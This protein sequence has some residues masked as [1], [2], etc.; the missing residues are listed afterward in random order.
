MF[1][2]LHKSLISKFLQHTLTNTHF[3]HTHTLTVTHSRLY[4]TVVFTRWS[5]AKTR[6]QTENNTGRV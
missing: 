2:N 6:P 1:P 4:L 5:T 3:Y